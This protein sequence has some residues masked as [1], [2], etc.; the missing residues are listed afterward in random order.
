MTRSR[1][2]WL[3]VALV[4]AVVVTIAGVGVFSYGST[5]ISGGVL[6]SDHPTQGGLYV[7][8]AKV[9]TDSTDSSDYLSYCAAPGGRFATLIW[10]R[11]DGPLPVTVQGADPGPGGPVSDTHDTNGFSLG[12]LAVANVAGDND[13]RTADVLPATALGPGQTITAWARFL[14]GPR[15]DLTPS[16]TRYTSQI[17]VRIGILGVTK[18]VSVSLG[19]PGVAMAGDC[20]R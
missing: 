18:V 19:S 16:L 3:A 20:P 13:P 10:L 5:N 17:W 15:V 2:R 1:R 7:G 11:N 12:D 14:E 4:V 6:S 8:V 9:G